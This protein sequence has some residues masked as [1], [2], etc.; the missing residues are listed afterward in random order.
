MP[1]SPT[2]PLRPQ[3]EIPL[4][5]FGT[6]PMKGDECRRAVETA[7]DC[8]YRHLD[9]ADAY[10][11]HDAVGAALQSAAVPREQ[12]FLTTKVMRDKLRYEQV[13]EV[14]E[15]SL[16]ELQ[17]DYLDLFLVHWPNNEIPME[18]TFRAMARLIEEGKIRAC[19]VS[20]FTVSRLDR[21]LALDLGPISV[22]QVEYHPFLNQ[23]DL[24]RFCTERGVALTA[25]SPLA[26]GKIAGDPTLEEIAQKYGKSPA[27]VTLRWLLQRGIVA[28]PKA[29]SRPHIEANLNILDFELSS[30]DFRR[31][32]NRERWER[33][34][35]WDVADFDD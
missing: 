15:R 3:G 31:I 5:G 12:I 9:T 1:D 21:A 24:H 23:K 10:G 11:N 18:E 22:N 29:S 33:L 34:I 2:L 28:I 32:D 25:Y 19:G 8:G 35:T 13:I 27:Q 16:R 17:T 20:N 26:Q 6:Y 4:L 30:E 7:L 14:A